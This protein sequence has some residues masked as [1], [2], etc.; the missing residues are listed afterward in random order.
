MDNREE[1]SRVNRRAF[2]KGGSADGL[3][4]ANLRDS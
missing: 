2:V 4:L 1:R 3:K